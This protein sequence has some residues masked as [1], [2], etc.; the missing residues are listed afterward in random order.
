M[1]LPRIDVQA[2]TAEERLD[3]ISRIWE[4]FTRDPDSLPLTPVQADELDRRMDLL[5]QGRMP[6]VPWEELQT[7]KPGTPPSSHPR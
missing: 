2:M 4:S 1:G 6:L 3:L 7:R 5:D